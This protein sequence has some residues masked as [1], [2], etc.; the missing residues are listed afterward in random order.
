MKKDGWIPSLIRWEDYVK[1]LENINPDSA[2]EYLQ[3][4]VELTNTAREAK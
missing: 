1:G 4:Y 3:K 2:V